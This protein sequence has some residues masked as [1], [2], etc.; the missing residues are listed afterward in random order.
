MPR[1]A[2]LAPEGEHPLE[3]QADLTR[4]TIASTDV[5]PDIPVPSE[6]DWTPFASPGSVCLARGSEGRRLGVE[7]GPRV[8]NGVG[9]ESMKE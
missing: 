4:M 1:R 8:G 3:R 7:K 9:N 6:H 5:T 2:A